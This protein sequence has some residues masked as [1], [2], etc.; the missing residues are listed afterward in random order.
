MKIFSAVAAAGLAMTVASG[1]SG[2]EASAPRPT[3]AGLYVL[4]TVDGKPLPVELATGTNWTHGVTSGTLELTASVYS[5]TLNFYDTFP[6]FPGGRAPSTVKVSGFGV[7]TVKDASI[8]FDSRGGDNAEFVWPRSGVV[9][10]SSIT[11]AIDGHTYRF[12]KQ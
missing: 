6:G 11:Y 3:L 5:R 2:S 12:Q 1:C 7:Y 10:G 8:L 4:A 9:N